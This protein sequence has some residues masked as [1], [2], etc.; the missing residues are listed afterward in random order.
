MKWAYRR[1][2]TWIMR[3]TDCMSGALSLM[4]ASPITDRW[5]SKPWFGVD[6]QT[7]WISG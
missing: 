2:N 7:R 5:W 3:W 4:D 1:R 6:M